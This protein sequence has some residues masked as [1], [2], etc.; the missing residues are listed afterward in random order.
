MTKLLFIIAMFFFHVVDDYYLQGVLAK[1]KQKKWWEQNAPNKIY[2]HDY[3]VALITHAFSWSAMVHIPAVAY[4]YITDGS[5]TFSVFIFATSIA[6]HAIIDD[7]KANKLKI[8]LWQD[9]IMHFVQI[10]CIAAA[11]MGEFVT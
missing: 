6:L 4:R 5:V 3:I 2:K 8:N 1:M 10:V 9:Q 7:M 11:Y